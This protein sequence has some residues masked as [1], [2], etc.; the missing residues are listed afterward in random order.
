MAA[1][2]QGGP[3]V[4]RTQPNLVD[5]DLFEGEWWVAQTAIDA[6]ADAN[7]PTFTGDMGWAD[8]GIDQGE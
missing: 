4:D 7:G 1:C 8:L 5:K 3:T 6:D 2:T